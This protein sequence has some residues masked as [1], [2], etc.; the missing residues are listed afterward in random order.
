MLRYGQSDADGIAISERLMTAL[1]IAPSE[2]LA[3]AY[4]DLAAR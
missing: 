4:L 3:G 1:D 2:R